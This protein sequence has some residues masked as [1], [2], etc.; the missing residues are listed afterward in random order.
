MRK[1]AL[2]Y[3]LEWWCT[4]AQL[5]CPTHVVHPISF[6]ECQFFSFWTYD[7]IFFTYWMFF[8]YWVVRAKLTEILVDCSDCLGL[9]WQGKKFITYYW[10]ECDW[11]VSRKSQQRYEMSKWHS[12]VQLSPTQTECKKALN[13]EILRDL[14]KILALKKIAKTWRLTVEHMYFCK[15]ATCAPANSHCSCL[16]NVTLKKGCL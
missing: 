14:L 11:P 12:S 13:F 7:N 9:K 8:T 5:F 10:T 1:C 3:L 16:L 2:K 15:R 6:F 4:L